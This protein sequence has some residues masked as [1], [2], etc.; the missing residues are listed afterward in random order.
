MFSGILSILIE[1]SHTH[2]YTEVRTAPYIGNNITTWTYPYISAG[3]IISIAQ[4]KE[5]GL[6][7]YAMIERLSSEGDYEIDS[8]TTGVVFI[9]V[10]MWQRW[11]LKVS[12]DS[13]S[14]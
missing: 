12:T 10:A 11:C 4:V 3:L 6:S 7:W 1:L 14:D 9:Y 2:V 13:I 8:G 5:S